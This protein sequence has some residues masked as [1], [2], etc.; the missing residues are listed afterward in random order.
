MMHIS[1]YFSNITS[2]IH[3]CHTRN[4]TPWLFQHSIFSALIKVNS[5]PD[6][7]Y[8]YIR[9]NLNLNYLFIL[10]IDLVFEM[11]REETRDKAERIYIQKGEE[12]CQS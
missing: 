10:I 9:N 3:A 2:E 5:F 1:F 4:L 7:Y 12:R 11:D 6:S 8:K